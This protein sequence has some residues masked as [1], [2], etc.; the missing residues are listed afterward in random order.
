MEGSKSKILII[1]DDAALCELL[2][3]YLGPSYDVK[4]TINSL[5]AWEWLREGNFPDLILTDFKM[6]YVNGSELIENLRTSGLYKE[7]PIII[8]TG[9]KERSLLDHCE[10]WGIDTIVTKPF[11]PEDLIMTI[12]NT[13]KQ[14]KHA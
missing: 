1:E 5:L 2:D 10:T 3:T 4:A 6:P 13:L 7:I 8:L 12:E 9:S 11:N 14:T